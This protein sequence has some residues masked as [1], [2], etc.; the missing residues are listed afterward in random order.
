MQV[1]NWPVSE[2]RA[3]P[4]SCSSSEAEFVPRYDR[5]AGS[6]DNFTVF[7]SNL[8]GAQNVVTRSSVSDERA[9]TAAARTS[10]PPQRDSVGTTLPRAPQL[11]VTSLDEV[12]A[13][14]RG[15]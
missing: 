13:G 8:P 6:R 5:I 1:V 15:G 12:G 9:P 10:F 4:D 11:I 2:S 7:T 14:G 3:D